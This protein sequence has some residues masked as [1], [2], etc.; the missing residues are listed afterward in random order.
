MTKYIEIIYEESRFTT[1]FI[2][3]TPSILTAGGY[4][5]IH[6]NIQTQLKVT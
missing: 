3:Q 1:Q 5:H 6:R 4:S 2:D